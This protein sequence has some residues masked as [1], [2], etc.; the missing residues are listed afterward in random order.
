M[1]AILAIDPGSTESGYVLYGGESP[2]SQFGKVGNDDL[3]KVMSTLPEPPV[4]A[5][6]MVASYGMAVGATVFE[7]CVWIG[8]FEQR[9]RDLGYAVHR[10]VRKEVKMHL[11]G[12]NR[13][14]D[15]N[16]VKAVS[17]RM[18][19][20]YWSGGGSN[21]S[22]GTKDQPGPCYGVKADVWQALA[23]AITFDEA[24]ALAPLVR[25]VGR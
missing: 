3:L 14:K 4:V 2:I 22:R 21:P 5:L 13:A 8:R 18:T 24:E 10:I 6:E 20:L 25:G 15:S 12:T 23:L 11:C 17:D 16:I 1:S 7:T 19:D 9:A